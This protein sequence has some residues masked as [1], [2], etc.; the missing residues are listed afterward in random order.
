WSPPEPHGV[1][2]ANLLALYGVL[3]AT[4]C[5]EAEAP[6]I[7]R[8]HRA[9]RKAPLTIGAALT[10]IRGLSGT[11]VLAALAKGYLFGPLHSVPLDEADR[12]PLFVTKSQASECDD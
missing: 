1:Y 7:A 6:C 3:S 8:L 5:E 9:L 11:H 12:F 2:Q 4:G 10:L